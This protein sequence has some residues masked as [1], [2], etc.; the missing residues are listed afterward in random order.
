[1][2]YLLSARVVSVAKEGVERQSNI[3]CRLAEPGKGGPLGNNP[4]HTHDR[5]SP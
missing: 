4:K 5:H 1:M 2:K 3:F